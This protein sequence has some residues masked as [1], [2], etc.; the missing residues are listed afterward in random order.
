MIQ[1]PGPI[2]PQIDAHDDHAAADAYL[3]VRA[4]LS[5]YLVLIAFFILLTAV[6]SFNGSK[7]E[8]AMASV[9]AA[10][11]SKLG[12]GVPEDHTTS[13][14]VEAQRSY[15]EQVGR[16]LAAALPTASLERPQRGNQ[17]EASVPL[18]VLFQP[19]SA[20]ITGAA[21]GLL[22]QLVPILAAKSEAGTLSLEWL[23][24]DPGAGTEPAS[25]LMLGRASTLA[26]RLVALGAPQPAIAVG[27]DPKAGDRARLLFYARPADA[28]RLDFKGL[29]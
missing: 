1:R 12:F 8:Q 6:S 20:E 18:E 2:R 21:D 27:L 4:F 28:P 19:G 25:R 24:P 11:P 5:L 15:A 17:I 10:F 23:L 16:L 22:Q 14:F 26:R 29:S 13:L 9:R 7:A 3:P